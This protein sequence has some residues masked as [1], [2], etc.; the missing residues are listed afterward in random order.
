ME[1]AE[2]AL[3]IV[4]NGYR[5]LLDIALNKLTL[6]R[7]LVSTIKA[8]KEGTRDFHRAMDYLDRAVEGLREAGQVQYLAPGLIIRAACYRLQE[9]LSRA[10][11]DLNEAKEI[12]E[13][14]EMKL[15]LVDYHIEA[16]RV[17]ST[18]GKE[19]DARFHLKTAEKMIKETGYHRRDEEIMNFE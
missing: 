10:W 8:E 18:E 2:K 9:N 15:Y 13:L 12:A 6:G 14:G 7:A 11:E 5:N 19:T 17:R 4:L 1:R 16:A 3:E